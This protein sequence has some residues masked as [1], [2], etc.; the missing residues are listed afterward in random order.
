MGSKLGSAIIDTKNKAP[1]PGSYE[2]H[3]KDKKDAPKFGFGSSKRPEITGKKGLD[4][5]GPGSYKINTKVGDVPNYSMPREEH[6]KY[7]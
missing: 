2:S 6:H 1:G 3:L 4:G 5:P 7:V